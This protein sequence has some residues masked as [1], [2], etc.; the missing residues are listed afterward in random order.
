MSKAKFQF[1]ASWDSKSAD[2][3]ESG[4]NSYTD[5]EPD[6]RL[7][8]FRAPLQAKAPSRTQNEQVQPRSA[9]A[10]CVRH[11]A[12]PQRAALQH[13]PT[14]S[15]HSNPHAAR[16]TASDARRAA[17]RTPPRPARHPDGRGDTARS[18]ARPYGRPAR[19]SPAR[20][21]NS[22]PPGSLGRS[23]RP[24]PT[25][26]AAPRLPARAPRLRAATASGAPR[27][28]PAAPRGDAALLP[29]PLACPPHPRPPVSPFL[30]SPEPFL[31]PCLLPPPSPSRGNSQETRGPATLTF[32]GFFPPRQRAAELAQEGV[33]LFSGRG[34]FRG[35]RFGGRRGLLGGR[36]H[37]G[38]AGAR[39]WRRRLR[40][41][42]AVGGRSRL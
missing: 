6:C 36:C 18:C 7:S 17:G 22:E 1:S 16:T 23:A 24:G 31:S 13:T 41:P 2:A 10:S 12:F 3:A 27:P 19:P 37:G 38:R 30:R 40:G 14:D 8:V 21:T 35:G 33:I 29:S 4:I 28:A 15:A 20:G 26:A 39:G 42:G 11:P 25:A 9:A 32:F 34:R 5:K